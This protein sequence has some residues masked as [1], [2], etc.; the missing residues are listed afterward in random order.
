MKDKK[1]GLGE[2]V[3]MKKDESMCVGEGERPFGGVEVGG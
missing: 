2:E 3:R 1:C